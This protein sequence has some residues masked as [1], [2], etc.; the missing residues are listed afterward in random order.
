MQE[1]ARVDAD[2]AFV[3]R[4]QATRRFFRLASHPELDLLAPGESPRAG[5]M[6]ASLMGA[7][8]HE[9]TQRQVG[10][11]TRAIGTMGSPSLLPSSPHSPVSVQN[12][13]ARQKWLDARGKQ[14]VEQWLDARIH[15]TEQQD[16]RSDWL[17]EVSG[18][19]SLC[20]AT[21][22][23]YTADGMEPREHFSQD[24]G[25]GEMPRPNEEMCCPTLRDASCSQRDAPLHHNQGPALPSRALCEP[26][27]K[28]EEL[29]R[30]SEKS[31]NFGT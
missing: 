19:C 12:Q 22:S 26:E 27:Q 3:K 6:L 13:T 17:G 5:A 20:S 4:R 23:E 10:T 31:K 9:S 11:L 16:S 18:D 21:S 8:I 25:T 30:T 7:R 24:G 14:T 28:I 29:R 15:S 2:D 1:S